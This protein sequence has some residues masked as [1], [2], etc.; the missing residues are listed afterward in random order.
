MMP[1]FPCNTLPS[2]FSSLALTKACEENSF[3]SIANIYCSIRKKKKKVPAKE[4]ELSPEASHLQPNSE[5]GRWL[6]GPGS[7]CRAQVPSSGLS[8]SHF[9]SALTLKESIPT[10]ARPSH[11]SIKKKRI[12]ILHN[13]DFFPLTHLTNRNLS[14]DFFQLPF[15][16]CQQTLVPFF[17]PLLHPLQSVN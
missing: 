8:C 4:K 16:S 10:T 11:L 1:H 14:F 17:P 3:L 12:K 5:A 7:S 2:R 13:P 9:K 6:E 15:F